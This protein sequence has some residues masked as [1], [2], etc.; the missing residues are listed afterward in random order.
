VHIK[1][2]IIP[3]SYLRKNL[4]ARLDLERKSVFS[5]LPYF[6]QQPLYALRD[7]PLPTTDN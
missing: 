2:I 3:T 5:G 6:I 1:S 4:S 7:P